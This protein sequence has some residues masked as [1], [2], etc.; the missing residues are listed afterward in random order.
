MSIKLK[1]YCDGGSRG[2]P[3]P[4]AS[5]FVVYKDTEC[6]KKRSKFLGNRTNNYA[7]YVA[8]G[9]AIRWFVS[10]KYNDKTTSVKIF[11]DSELVVNQVNGKYKIKS[12]SLL[13]LATRLKTLLSQIQGNIQI[14]SV[15]REKNKTAD[16]LVNKQLDNN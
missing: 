7:E 8:L 3:G 15:K 12:K 2:N 11:M 13:P 16:E 9:M 10:S 6:I 14:T 1:I 5:A 4:A